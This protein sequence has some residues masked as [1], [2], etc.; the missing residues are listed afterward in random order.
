[1][2]RTAKPKNARV[3][4]A[5]RERE[6]QAQENPK[7]A[8]FIK[9]Q[10]TSAIVNE[11][12]S[13]LY[14]LKKPHGITFNKKNQLQPFEDSSSLEFWSNKNDA[15]LLLVGSHQKKRPH[16]LIFT[17]TFNY[18]L[19]DMF[20]LGVENFKS[21][22]SF[23]INNQVSV[24]MKPLFNFTGELFDTHPK[25][26]QF[27]NVML[28]FFRGE[29]LSSISLAGLSHVISCTV[30]EQANEEDTPP[31]QFRVYSIQLLKSGTRTPRVE[32][33]EMGPS[34][35]L[36]PRRAQE[37]DSSLEKEAY[38]KPKPVNVPKKRKNVEVDEMG[39][40]V[41]RIHMEKQ[42]L[43]KLQTRKVKAL[44]SDD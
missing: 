41:G 22:K 39:D 31:I 4:R 3:K 1:M 20:E 25:Y 11:A 5:M 7:T 29:T 17:R 8:L 33:V 43:S 40:K 34:M 42:D 44:K 18:Q 21:M 26:Q 9:T 23:N 30:G 6:P 36:T 38:R 32:L 35:D 12:M 16:N 14:S 19:F 28:D 10:T 2:L 27:K 13:D 15:S 37:P 24:G